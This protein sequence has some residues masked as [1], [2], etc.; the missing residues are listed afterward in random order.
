MCN[1]KTP[2]AKIDKRSYVIFC[3]DKEKDISQSY[4]KTL[5][6]TSISKKQNDNTKT[7]PKL[8][9]HNNYGPT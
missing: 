9:L 3:G 8:Q 7:P 1:L 6:T 5:T 4:D 2:N